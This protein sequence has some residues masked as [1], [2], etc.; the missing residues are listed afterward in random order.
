MG[1]CCCCCC[2]IYIFIYS[3]QPSAMDLLPVPQGSNGYF[4][5]GFSWYDSNCLLVKGTH[6]Q[7]HRCTVEPKLR[8]FVFSPKISSSE[9]KK[10][11]N[12]R[13]AL[14]SAFFP[15]LFLKLETDILTNWLQPSSITLRKSQANRPKQ[16]LQYFLYFLI[17]IILF[18]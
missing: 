1:L 14:K 3:G 12:T 18:F 4:V 2:Y 11:V 7:V 10:I 15:F 8:S 5:I 9:F 13:L 6:L 17:I 16:W